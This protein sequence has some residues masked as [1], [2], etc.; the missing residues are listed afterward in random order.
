MPIPF[1]EEVLVTERRLVSVLTLPSER[2]DPPRPG[3]VILNSG[4]THRVGAGRMSVS[5]A[6]RLAGLGHLVARF[7]HA[8]VGDSPPRRDS[9]DLE[10]GRLTDIDEMLSTLTRRFGVGEFVIYGLCSGARDA[11]H[12]AVGDPRV[13]GIVQ[14]D[15]FAYP[16]VR[17]LVNR[18]AGRLRDP[19]GM[20]GTVA[21]LLGLRSAAPSSPGE[22]MWVQEWSEYP[23]REQVE[24]GYER[25]VERGV[26]IF[27][28]YTGSWAHQY[29]YERQFFDMFPDVDFGS[30]L[31]LRYLPEAE[32]TLLDPHQR[33][34]VCND[35]C[36]WLNGSFRVGRATTV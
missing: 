17:H 20:M 23:P 33:E 30:L 8:G 36:R 21:R 26:R 22:D 14:I 9:L 19:R 24:A 5:M 25:L 15:G 31:E 2:S 27:A 4:V 13:V 32:H 34:I 10:Q 11:Y 18:V 6:R 3:V 16:N 7:D 29:N 12:A 35:L 1:R 28:V